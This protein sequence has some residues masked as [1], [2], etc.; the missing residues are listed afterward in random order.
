MSCV[1]C[2][3]LDDPQHRERCQEHS[4]EPAELC[5]CHATDLQALAGRRHY[6]AGQCGGVE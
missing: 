4:D 3:G 5:E 1:G 2:V 6:P